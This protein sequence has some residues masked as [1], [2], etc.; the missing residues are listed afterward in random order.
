MQGSISFEDAIKRLEEIVKELES[1]ELEIEKALT[2]FEEGTR[3]S[4]ICAKKL[5]NIER[6]IEILKKG[7]K[8]QDIL[9][10]FQ[11]LDEEQS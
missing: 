7:E 8:D 1:G 3:L 10:L 9:E 4:K 2:M 6:R 11:D 5:S